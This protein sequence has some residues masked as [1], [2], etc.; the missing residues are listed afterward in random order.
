[1]SV[2]GNRLFKVKRRLRLELTLYL[3]RN[4]N[5]NVSDGKIEKSVLGTG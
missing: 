1:M 2:M 3:K 4:G 5:L